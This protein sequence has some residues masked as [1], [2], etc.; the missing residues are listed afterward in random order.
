MNI[1]SVL[2]STTVAGFAMAQ[3]AQAEVPHVVT[4]IPVVHSLVAQVMGELGTPDLL[5]DRGADPHNFQLRP[6]QAQAL[7]RADLLFWVGPE[8]TPWLVRAKEGV[9]LRGEAVEL[10]TVEGVSLRDFGHGHSHAHDDHGHD[11]DDH[12]HGHDDHGHDHDDHGHDHDD[13]G[14]DHDDH[15]HDHDDHGHGHDDHGHG[16]D[17][18]GH[19]HDDHGHGHDDHGHDHDDHGHGHDDHGHSHD[20]GHDHV[21]DGTDP[22]AWLYPAN[23]KVWLDA[24]AEVLATQ[25]PENADSY[26]ANAAAAIETVAA[27]EAEVRD[28]LA[29][30]GDAPVVVFHDAYGYFS[31]AFGV[32]VVGTVTLGDAA[33]PGAARLSELRG[34][35]RDGGVVCIFPEVNHSSRHVD[36]LVEGTDTRV[37]PLL[38]PA[39]VAMDPGPGLYGELMRSLAIGMA[40]CVAEG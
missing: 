40:E 3:S 19:D 12:G 27:L 16:H 37:G 5:L 32:N 7:A 34:M 30:V 24:I 9:G 4:D 8:M 2:L 33:P 20:H 15:G 26:R 11:H 10:L 21:H 25:D 18:H 17:N 14:H 39:G 36:M 22:H 6:T 29:P 23:A 35:L 31:Q 38:D 28:L 13:H 1:R